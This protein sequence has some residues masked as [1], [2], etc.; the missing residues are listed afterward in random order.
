MVR[1]YSPS[2]IL[3]PRFLFDLLLLLKS[4]DFVEFMDCSAA[5]LQ[6]AKLMRTEAELKA[7]YE[8]EHE[9]WKATNL[10]RRRIEINILQDC[11][12]GVIETEEICA[13]E[14]AFGIKA[15]TALFAR[16]GAETNDRRQYEIDFGHMAMLQKR[17]MLFGYHANAWEM[18]GFDEEKHVQFFNEDIAFLEAQGLEINC[19]SPHGAR[20]SPDGRH[21]ASFFAPAFASKPLVWTHNR[22]AP[23]G[24]R[25]GDG[26][27]WPRLRNGDPSSDIRNYL[28]KHLAFGRRLWILFHP[29]YYSGSSPDLV[30]GMSALPWPAEYWHGYQSGRPQSFWEPVRRHLDRLVETGAKANAL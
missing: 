2:G 1:A 6:P 28:L 17:G 27:F 13:F 14:S 23:R 15:T 8:Q 20:P 10:K 3:P 26:D 11:D 21:N 16:R 5:S 19:F 12:H 29:Q 24:A 18:S 25:Q 9:V 4:Y 7:F 22:I 30:T